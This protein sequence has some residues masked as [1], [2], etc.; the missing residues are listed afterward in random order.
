MICEGIVWQ[1][2][3]LQRLGRA[4]RCD[5]KAERGGAVAR[6]SGAGIC[7]GTVKHRNESY[8]K[9]RAERR[10]EKLRPAA[11]KRRDDLRRVRNT[12]R[13]T[14]INLHNPPKMCGG[15]KKGAK[16][17]PVFGTNDTS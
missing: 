1:G 7:R 4:E 12:R 10:L 9:G 15:Y 8:C 5:G 13:I 3:D 11:A 17:L 6:K 2:G 16:P 14:L